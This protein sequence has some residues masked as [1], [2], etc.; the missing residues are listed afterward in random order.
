MAKDTDDERNAKLFSFWFIYSLDKA[1]SLRLGRASTIQDYDISVPLPIPDQS[2][3][4]SAEMSKGMYCWIKLASLQ[5]QIYELLY[6]PGSFNK[7]Q[8][9][10]AATADRL[11]R[12]V[13]EVIDLRRTV[14]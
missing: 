1:L 2:H 10:R 5:G 14:S 11:D 7:S 3:P 9:E 8:A 13:Q 6:S 12:E 4:G